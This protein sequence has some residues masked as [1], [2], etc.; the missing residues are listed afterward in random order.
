MP[1]IRICYD[2][3]GWAYHRRA[4]ALKKYAPPGWDVT[5][6][7]NYGQAFRDKPHELA[8]Q[9]CY[10]YAKPIREH[11]TRGGYKMK[12]VIGFNVAWEAQDGWFAKCLKYGDWVVVNS[13]LC[14]EKSGRLERTSWISNGVDHEVFRVKAPIPTRKPKVLWVGSHFHKDNKG[15]NAILLPLAD[16]LQREHGI[17]CDFRLT[18][19]HSARRLNADQMCEY[20]NTGT[21]YVCASKHEGTPNPALEAASCGCVVVSTPVGNM[22]ELIE[23][24]VNGRL[25]PREVNPLMRAIVSCQERYEEMAGAMQERILPWHWQQRAPQYYE[26][27][28]RL[29][30]TPS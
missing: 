7:G 11:I 26:L 14:W 15:Y 25:V 19:S 18:N 10:P 30:A 6:G 13:R 28:E 23:D 5:I 20:Y 22:P 29:L 2:V 8:V 1:T 17:D 12:L 9:L 21:I 16:K 4:T 24:G 3:D 27:F